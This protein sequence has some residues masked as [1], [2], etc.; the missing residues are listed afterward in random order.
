MGEDGTSAIS[1]GSIT[2]SDDVWIGTRAIILSGVN[3]GQGAIIAA[4]SV[5]TKDV[6]AYA[7]VAGIPARIIKYRFS[8]EMINLLLK[9]DFSKL[10]KDFI[11]KHK[12]QL[13][14]PLK[15]EEQV[16]FLLQ[17]LGKQ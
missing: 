7:V 4:G 9:F 3:I 1:K 5:V 6:P 11:I 13:Q 8:N 16:S 17:E 14:L 12:E 2:V 15:N 10:D